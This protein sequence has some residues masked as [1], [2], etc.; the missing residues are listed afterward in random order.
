MDQTI[1]QIICGVLAVACVVIIVMRRMGK[2]KTQVDE[3]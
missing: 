1:V 3:C 2:K